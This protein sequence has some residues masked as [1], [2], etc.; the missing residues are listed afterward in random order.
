MKYLAGLTLAILLLL[1]MATYAALGDTTEVVIFTS[2][3]CPYC[4]KT[5][6]HLEDLTK[7]KTFDFKVTEYDVRKY[8]AEI[9]RFSDFAYVYGTDTNQVPMTFI[10]Q[11]VIKGLQPEA[12]DKAL[13]Y[14][15]KNDCKDASDYVAESLKTKPRPLTELEQS[16]GDNNM[17][18]LG[19]VV[20]GVLAV[21]GVLMVWLNR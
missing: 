5:K 12:I 11:T 10:G 9:K 17:K 2:T 3:G 18:L 13:D 16:A 21:G 19:W 20:L 6:A 4:A 15:K 1:P 8:P 14:C 7:N